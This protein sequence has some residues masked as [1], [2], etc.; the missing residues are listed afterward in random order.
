MIDILLINGTVITMDNSRRIIE[1]GAVAVKGDRIHEVGSAKEL[2]EK[3]EKGAKKVIDCY[4]KLILPGFID[5]HSHAGHC[6]FKSLAYDTS[7][8]WMPIMMELYHH[9][10]T[11]E[12]WYKDGK[13]AALER[14]KFGVTCGVSMISNAQRSDNAVFPVN[15]GKGYAEVG[16]REV[17]AVGP[18]NPPFPRPFSRLLNGK[19]IK[20][21][22]TFDELMDGTEET[23]K[24]ANHMADD[25]IRVFVAPFVMV[26]SVN[27]SNQ[28]APDVAANLSKHDRYM[29]AK[30][31][32]MAKKYNT[33]IHT[34]AFGGMIRLAATDENALLGPDV[35]V[36]HCRG[37]STDEIRILAETKTHVSSSPSAAQIFN[38]CPVPELMEFGAN[39]AI[40]TDGT[41][42]GVSFD[43]L[44]AAKNTR[45]LHQ[46]FLHNTYYLPQ[47]KLLEMITIDAAKAIGWDDELGSIEVGKKADIITV[48]MNQPHLTPD[49]MP[50]HKLLIFGT[51]QDVDNTI[52]NGKLLMENRRVLS[53][54]EFDVIKEAEEESLAT[55]DRAGARKYMEPCDTF[56]G[57]TRAYV[58][59]NR[60]EPVE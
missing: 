60:Y 10:T 24:Q 37:I 13:L 15:H 41:S 52:I 2:K 22:Y 7:S 53:V 56:W 4:K 51:G 21:E 38:R 29:T 45:M 23:I 43:M 20:T 42:P 50:V 6:M 12:F 33:R 55:I 46:G 40:S 48:N 16:V 57:N 25:L 11:D 47:G 9:N 26:T 17:L 32:E 36:Q 3:Y 35:H 54:D 1:N 58:N 39:V 44:I 19:W 14:L 31:R 34:E 18:S 5:T 59:E 49:F 8:Y 28:T 30:V 27:Q